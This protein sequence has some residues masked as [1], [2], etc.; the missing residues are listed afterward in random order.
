MLRNVKY[1][2][3]LYYRPLKQPCSEQL[4]KASMPAQSNATICLCLVIYPGR[5]GLERCLKSAQGFIDA[6][7]VVDLSNQSGTQ[8]IV[9]G[10]LGH[11]PGGYS[12]QTFISQAEAKN[13]ALREAE[14]FSDLALLLE[15]DEELLVLEN[16]LNLGSEYTLG[17]IEVR[18]SGYSLR[19][20]RLIRLKQG[21]TM[22]N[23][24]TPTIKSIEQYAATLL[25]KVAINCT[26]PGAWR[27]ATHTRDVA[28]IRAE[29]EQS[30]NNHALKL[31]YAKRLIAQKQFDEAEALLLALSD[32]EPARELTWMA[33]YLLGNLA[34]EAEQLSEAKEAFQQCIELDAGRA[35][36][37]MRIMLI[38]SQ[39]NRL[40]DAL[41][42]GKLIIDLEPAAHAD[43][44]EPSVYLF[45]AKLELAELFFR[46]GDTE[47]TRL[48]ARSVAKHGEI[49][50]PSL[51]RIKYLADAPDQSDPVARALQIQNTKSLANKAPAIAKHTA[52][53]PTLS[54]GMATYDDFDGVYFSIMSILLY[55]QDVL[56]QIE[57]IVVD[58]NPESEHGKA[59]KSVC[60]AAAN[61]RY[62]PA[63]EYQ[64]TTVRERVFSEARGDFV[65]CMD[66][67][68]FL[69]QGALA[70][71]LDYCQNNPESGDLFHG[72]MVSEDGRLFTTHMNPVWRAGFYGAYDNDERGKQFDHE[73]FE[74]PMQGLGLFAC[75]RQAW[76]GF[77]RKFRGFGGE[78]GYIHE[79][80]RQAGGNVLCLPFLRWTHRFQRPAG[81]RYVNAW[82]DRIRNYL[83]GWNE[84]GMD[85]NSIY[86]HFARHVGSDITARVNA[87]FQA[88]QRGPLWAFDSIYSIDSNKAEEQHPL[89]ARLSIEKVTIAIQ[90]STLVS[91]VLFALNLAQQQNLPDAV[92]IHT[93]GL[94]AI[95]S[96]LDARLR[97]IS[98]HP[99]QSCL[100][101]ELGSAE[102]DKHASEMAISDANRPFIFIARAAAFAALQKSLL[103]SH[104]FSEESL[105][106][107]GLELVRL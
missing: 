44:I 34:A 14:N 10:S 17:M 67:H 18:H 90:Q 68:V 107:Q 38:L 75:R 53:A 33:N 88:E 95:D 93:A 16:H 91:G 96:D 6:W 25:P 82:E 106:A 7:V 11:L 43:Y 55:Q 52:T 56:E 77:S 61:I 49:P 48:I 47:N 89:L 105:L 99:D 27:T 104:A 66:C 79:K 46:V 19:E 29:L 1:S 50:K 81:T 12:Q 26:S 83:V 100:W 41:E 80:F 73:P 32:S 74:I 64:G 70:A 78:E 101:L 59:V 24:I 9:A 42:V 30:P 97:E 4:K 45:A 85:T 2:K 98:A 72:P 15:C 94:E 22:Q 39:E 23:V 76:P 62:I 71:M 51:N 102:T 3:I 21:A 20:S 87:R 103:E 60:N 84:L 69:H 65:L 35:E 40:N 57:L 28:L 86:A 58:N 13:F 36:P 8:A 54:I 5:S 37:Y 31:E 92:I 63:G